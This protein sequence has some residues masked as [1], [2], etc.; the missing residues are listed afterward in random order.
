MVFIQVLTATIERATGFRW[1]IY[2]HL[3]LISNRRGRSA[4]TGHDRARVRPYL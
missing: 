2:V 1:H 3:K 4:G